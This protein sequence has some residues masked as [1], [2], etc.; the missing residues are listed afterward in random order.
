M[1]SCK[2]TLI[3]L[4]MLTLP[5]A[6][7]R[8]GDPES[9]G[10]NREKLDRAAARLEAEVHQGKL[11]AASILVARRGAVVLH[12]GFGHL[13]FQPE[14]PAVQPDSVYIVASITKPV[15]VTALMT[16]VERG[17]ISLADPVSIYIPEF[18]GGDRDK[19]LVG[20]LLKHTSGMPDMLPENVELRRAH[21]PITEF[22]K[23]AIATPLLFAPGSAFRYQSMGIL[24]AAEI[25]QRVSGTSLRE[26]DRQ[27]IFEPLGMQRTQL[28]ADGL[29]LADTV[30]V[31]TDPHENSED[32]VSW[33]PN[34]VYWRNFGA[35]WGGMHTSTG[36]LA[37]LLEAFLQ[38]GVYGGQRILSPATVKEM[39]SDQNGSLHAPWGLGWALGRSKAWNE[40]G[41]LVSPKAFGHAGATGT[42]A[43]ADPETGLICVVLTNRPLS[44][45]NG[46][47]LRL[48]SNIVAASVE[49]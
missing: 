16:L 24:L 10:I 9:V 46:R 39:T 21:A 18:K 35:P 31:W 40:F 34:S 44:V 37:V 30:Q 1:K 23:H 36:D 25:V 17:L 45:D 14:S 8:I 33:G 6:Q 15:T 3:L 49:K 32:A 5:A 7:L 12:Q 4:P 26:F 27:Q 11:G 22:V 28:G 43:W 2:L 29:R 41:D 20:D 47:L 48:V 38:G 42:V 13:S 19:V